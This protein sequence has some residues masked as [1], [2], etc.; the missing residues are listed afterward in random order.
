MDSNTTELTKLLKKIKVDTSI[1]DILR[2]EVNMIIE[3]ISKF[4]HK[5][6]ISDLDLTENNEII[7]NQFMPDRVKNQKRFPKN[8]IIEKI[9]AIFDGL[10]HDQ[11]Q[12]MLLFEKFKSYLSDKNTMASNIY[13]KTLFDSLHFNNNFMTIIGTV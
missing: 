6:Y 11:L 10:T 12:K 2:L 7:A 5:L 4:I 9:I 8:L 3:V 1:V 13:V